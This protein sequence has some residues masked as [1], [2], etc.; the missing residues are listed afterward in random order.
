[1][2]PR[3]LLLGKLF[4]R[5]VQHHVDVEA[6]ED[7]L[8][9][10]DRDLADLDDKIS[11]AVELAERSSARRCQ[12]Q[13]QRLSVVKVHLLRQVGSIDE[14]KITGFRKGYGVRVCPTD[15]IDPRAL[16]AFILGGSWEAGRR[17][18]REELRAVYEP[19][20]S[21]LNSWLSKNGGKEV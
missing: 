16:E 3:P 13:M 20:K 9:Q 21:E 10:V 11:E 7:A 12:N 19:I 14:I 18:K 1:M 6:T 15:G 2:S 5:P 8:G 4:R 17:T